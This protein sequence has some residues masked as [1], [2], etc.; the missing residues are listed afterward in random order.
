MGLQQQTATRRGLE[1]SEPQTETLKADNLTV[2]QFN[3]AA[4]PLDP[5]AF[6]MPE[7]TVRFPV[8]VATVAPPAYTT[9][10]TML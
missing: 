2:A 10:S 4:V 9:W 7:F 8:T 5:V 1:F 6:P 3:M